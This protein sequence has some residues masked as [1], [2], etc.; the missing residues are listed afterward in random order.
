MNYTDIV[1]VIKESGEKNFTC[2][3]INGRV[4]TF[5]LE[6]YEDC[7]MAIPVIPNTSK[8]RAEINPLPRY[9]ARD[10]ISIIPTNKYKF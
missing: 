6:I 5:D 1:K 10:I 7:F 2:E 9:I 3:M 4:E 8:Y